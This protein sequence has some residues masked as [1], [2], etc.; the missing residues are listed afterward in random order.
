MQVW[1]SQILGDDHFKRM[2]RVTVSVAR[3]RTLTAQIPWMPSICQKLKPLTGY[4]DVSIWVNILEWDIKLQK[5]KNKKKKKY[6]RVYWLKLFLRWAIW[7]MDFPVLGLMKIILMPFISYC[8]KYTYR[9]LIL[10]SN[11]RKVRYCKNL[12]LKIQ[13]FIIGATKLTFI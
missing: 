4:G 12:K 2:P 13:Y 11:H 7:P 10:I 3:W 8:A 1:V 5:K 6:K 9:Y